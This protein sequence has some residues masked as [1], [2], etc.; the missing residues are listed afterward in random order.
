MIGII[1]AIV[2]TTVIVK[3][4]ENGLIEKRMN[5][6]EDENYYLRQENKKLNKMLGEE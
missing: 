4:V 5:E 2:F 3:M 6:L 1:V